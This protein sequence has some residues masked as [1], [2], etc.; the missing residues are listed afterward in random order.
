MPRST[1]QPPKYIGDYEVVKLIGE[2]G[3]ARVYLAKHV[4]LGRLDALKILR[5]EVRADPDA[6]PSS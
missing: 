3:Y 4:I 5:E 2:G 6:L 1:S